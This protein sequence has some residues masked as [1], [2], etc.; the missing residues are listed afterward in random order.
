MPAI[1]RLYDFQPGAVILSSQIDEEFN[2]LVVTVN[3]LPD[4]D[5]TL[6]TDLNA[7]LLD[8]FH[9]SAVGGTD[10]IPVCNED[11]QVGLNADLLDG[12]N[13]SDISSAAFDEGTKLLFYQASPPG[14]WTLVAAPT[15]HVLGWKSGATGGT[16][17]AN[18][19]TISGITLTINGTALT[20]AQLPAHTHAVGNHTHNMEHTHDLSNHTHEVSLHNTG[21]VLQYLVFASAGNNLG[22]NAGTAGVFVGNPAPVISDV[23]SNNNTGDASVSE[24]ALGGADNTTTVGSGTT[25]T[26]TGTASS[27]GVWRP[28]ISY[29]IIASKDGPPA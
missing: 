2:Q 22:F 4:A 26:H 11:L 28:P 1:N 20:I 9:A 24:T 25:H 21:L 17:V 16:N 8:G 15:D 14:G 7:D 27:D 3:T 5:G 10:T 19:W 12:L 29:I 18:S 6:Q 13:A 23:P